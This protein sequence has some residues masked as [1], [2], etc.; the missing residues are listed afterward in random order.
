MIVASG[1]QPSAQWSRT[2]AKKSAL[3]PSAAMIAD[4]LP[5]HGPKQEAP[6]GGGMS[7]RPW[8]ERRFK[9]RGS[10]AREPDEASRRAL[11]ER[12]QPPAPAR[13]VCLE[14]VGELVAGRPVRNIG[15]KSG[16]KPRPV[17]RSSCRHRLRQPSRVSAQERP[18]GRR[19]CPI[20]ARPTTTCC[21]TLQYKPQPGSRSCC[22]S[23]ARA[24]PRPAPPSAKRRPRVCY[25][26][27]AP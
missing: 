27:F 25:S 21:W 8:R 13:D 12:P 14:P 20:H 16:G 4:A 19:W 5:C 15:T 2:A 23:V 7:I 10:E 3:A 9:V 17:R 22:A 1:P 18:T 26:H 6:S 24:R 11:L